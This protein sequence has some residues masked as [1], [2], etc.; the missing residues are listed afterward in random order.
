MPLVNTASPQKIW[1]VKT[2]MDLPEANSGVVPTKDSQFV[3][4]KHLDDRLTSAGPATPSGVVMSNL[5]GDG[6]T[7]VGASCTAGTKTVTVSGWSGFV[8]GDV[9]KKVLLYNADVETIGTFVGS[10]AAVNGPSSVDLDR[11]VSTTVS[12]VMMCYGTDETAVFQDDIDRAAA[13]ALLHGGKVKLMVP[14][15]AKDHF[16]IAGPLRHDRQG[17]SQVMSPV[18]STLSHSLS[19]DIVGASDAST[20]QH[21]EQQIPSVGGSTF[22]SYFTY[23]SISAQLTDINNYGHSSVLGGPTEPSG[24]TQAAKFNNV[25][26][27]LTDLQIRTTHTKYGIGIGA[28]NLSSCKSGGVERFAWGTMSTYYQRVDLVG[29]YGAGM[30]VGLYLPT[31]GNNDKSYMINATCHGGYTYDLWVSEHTD[32]VSTRLLYGWAGLCVIG[33]YWSSVGTTHGVSGFISIEACQYFLYLFGAGS[34][35]EGPFLDLTIDTEGTLKIGDNNS[36]LASLSASGEIRL[37]GEIDPSTFTTDHPIG[38]D[39]RLFNKWYPNKGTS[40]NWTVDP[41][42]ELVVVDATANNVTISLPTADGRNRPITVVLDAVSGGHTCVIDPA[43][44]ETINGAA[45][46]TLS[47]VGDRIRVEPYNHRWVRTV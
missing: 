9:G 18:W 42:T 6:I 46:V 26:I 10:I 22:V 19:L 47:T 5:V 20:T 2:F 1:G 43:G 41:F 14:A 44:S 13:Y 32:F 28:A 39:V 34:G 36:G 12:N 29:N 31:A 33:N 16:V 45:T 27:T 8:A 7:L 11:N 3:T 23:S 4:K 21:W 35:G 37:M 25:E 24:Y 15:A 17:N 30:V 40:T 38:F